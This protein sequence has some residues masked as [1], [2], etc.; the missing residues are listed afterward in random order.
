MG[1]SMLQRFQ[2]FAAHVQPLGQI[3][4]TDGTGLSP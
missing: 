1:L 2:L 3:F 4:T